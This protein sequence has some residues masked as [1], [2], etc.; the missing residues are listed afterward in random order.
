MVVE[1]S[2]LGYLADYQTFT[3]PVFAKAILD[4]F[5]CKTLHRMD[6]TRLSSFF[7]PLSSFIILRCFFSFTFSFSF[8]LSDERQRQSTTLQ[9]STLSVTFHKHSRISINV[10][11]QWT[12]RYL[13]ICQQFGISQPIEISHFGTSHPV[14]IS[15]SGKFQRVEISHIQDSS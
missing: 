4:A 9:L 12:N 6:S 13:Q 7:S 5:C 1:M 14:E 2:F 3:F 11:S 8:S 10:N 15:H